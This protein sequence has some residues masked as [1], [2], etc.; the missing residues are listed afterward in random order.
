MSFGGGGSGGGAITAHRHNSQVGEGGPLQL[1]NSTT[2]GT[3]IQLNGG[4]EIVAEVLL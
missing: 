2:L 1:R 3:T 4:T